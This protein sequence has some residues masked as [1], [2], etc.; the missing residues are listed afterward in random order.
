[1]LSG[2]LGFGI[3]SS[4]LVA[5]STLGFQPPESVR[6]LPEKRKKNDK[7]IKCQKG[8]L[9]WPTIQAHTVVCKKVHKISFLDLKWQFSDF[10]LRGFQFH[11]IKQ[12]KNG[13]SNFKD[14]QF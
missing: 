13:H 9:K 1:L 3:F 7:I 2:S 14:F 4:L 8:G 10:K 6:S 12:L 5:S 11:F